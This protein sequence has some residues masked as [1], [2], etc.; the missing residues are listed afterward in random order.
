MFKKN[1]LHQ[2]QL[3]DQ[4]F[5]YQLTKTKKLSILYKINLAFLG[6]QSTLFDTK[7]FFKKSF[8]KKY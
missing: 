8:R 5:Q 2:R 4:P 3:E 6:R 1:D 7:F